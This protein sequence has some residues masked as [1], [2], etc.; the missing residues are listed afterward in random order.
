MV[1][2]SANSRLK[3]GFAVHPIPHGFDWAE[4]QIARFIGARSLPSRRHAN[5]IAF[6][7]SGG[8]RMAFIELV[9]GSAP[10]ARY[11]LD[12]ERA[13]IGRSA[14]CEIALDVPA[15]SRRHAAI[16]QDRGRYYV[17]D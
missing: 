6:A 7:R 11:E 14:D 4:A 10:G 3:Y 15:V 5:A 12:G 1:D 16:F 8:F 9:K 13:V 2:V 17:E